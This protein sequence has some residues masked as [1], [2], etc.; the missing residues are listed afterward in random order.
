MVKSRRGPGFTPEL[1]AEAVQLARQE[2]SFPNWSQ[3]AKG[4]EWREVRTSTSAEEAVKRCGFGV[5]GP[6]G[7]KRDWNG[8][9]WGPT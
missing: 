7:E 4:G 3:W 5:I 9:Q 1:A 6:N 8:E 2:V